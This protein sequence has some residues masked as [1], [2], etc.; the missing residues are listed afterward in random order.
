MLKNRRNLGG[1]ERSA[2]LLTELIP[3]R[4]LQTRGC[5]HGI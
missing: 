2:E 5:S 4:N 1:G 3:G